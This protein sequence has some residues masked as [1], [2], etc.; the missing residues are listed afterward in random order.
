DVPVP[1]GHS[2]EPVIAVRHEQCDEGEQTREEKEQ[3]TQSQRTDESGARRLLRRRC[4]A[5]LARRRSVGSGG[6][7]VGTR[8][9]TIGPGRRSVL[10]RCGAIGARGRSVL[11]R[12][13]AVGARCRGVL[14][15]CRTAGRRVVLLPGRGAV[16][17]TGSR[18]ERPR[19]RSVGRWLAA[20]LGHVLLLMLWGL[21][22]PRTW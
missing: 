19:A 18:P 5:E 4:R 20:G 12:T 1:Q 16:G 11:G 10:G 2:V 9:R 13:G 14:T 6:G 21:I 3:I 7:P 17:R 15:G 8:S 22:I